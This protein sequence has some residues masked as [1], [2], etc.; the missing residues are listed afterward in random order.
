MKQ[1]SADIPS[2]LM[3][4]KNVGSEDNGG[5]PFAIPKRMMAKDM[6]TAN[7]R[8]NIKNIPFIMALPPC[9]GV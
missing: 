4:I 2:T 3:Y 8:P 1:M 5:N 9:L 6:T 7:N